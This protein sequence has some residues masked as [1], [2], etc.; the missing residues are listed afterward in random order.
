[1]QEPTGETVNY[2]HNRSGKTGA[3]VSRD[4]TQGYGPECYV[5]PR[6]PPGQYAISAK[7]YASHQ[8]SQTTGGTSC[9][10]WS[11]THLGDWDREEANFTSVRLSENKSMERV[12]TLTLGAEE[13]KPD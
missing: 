8:A 2:S 1:M 3:A 10:I 7:F 6:G 5:L 11:I 9:I 12:L 13:G 4:F